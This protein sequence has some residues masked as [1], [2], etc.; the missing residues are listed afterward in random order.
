VRRHARPLLAVGLACVV[1]VGLVVADGVTLAKA[2]PSFNRET[3][4][5]RHLLE[6]ASTTPTPPKTTTTGPASPTVPSETNAPT[7]PTAPTTSTAPTALTTKTAP[8][9]VSGRNGSP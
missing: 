1:V 6:A 9:T 4:Y 8:A 5:F 3:Q 2:K 7:A